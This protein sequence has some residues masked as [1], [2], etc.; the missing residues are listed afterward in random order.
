PQAA[1]RNEVPR[2]EFV[3]LKGIPLAE[4]PPGAYVF[5]AEHFTEM[6]YAWEAH[7]DENS[8]GGTYFLCKEGIANNS[9]QTRY[10]VGNF[11]DVHA[12][13]DITY[14]KYHFN[15]PVGGNYYC[16]GRMC[17]TDTHC[18]NSL[19]VDFDQGGPGV[20]SMTNRTPVRWVWTE[21]VGNPRRLEKGDHYLHIFPWEDGIM[22]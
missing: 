13:A 8:S 2:A 10:M 15:L 14:L 5:E 3:K 11:Y 16:Y 18:S 21:I 20:G 17:T 12:S 1:V 7:G 22:I 19:S 6:N 9:A 4:P